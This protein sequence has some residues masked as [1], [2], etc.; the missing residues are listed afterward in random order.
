MGNNG[1]RI[2]I[3]S[4]GKLNSDFLKKYLENNRSDKI[5]C[6]DGALAIVDQLNIPIDYLVGDFD[7]ISSDVLQKYL[8]KIENGEM[9]TIV[10][11]FKP[12][13]D[14]T[15]TD[16]AIKLATSLKPSEII[17][18]GA[19]GTRVDHMMSNINS[20]FK[21]L[22]CNIKAFLIDEHNKI[23]LIKEETKLLKKELYGPFISLIAFTDKVLNVTLKGFKY[24]LLN[25]EL[26]KGESIGISN[27]MKEEE[28]VIELQKGII[29]VVEAKD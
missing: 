27:E 8:N 10:K 20:L 25:Y 13:K 26:T 15:D 23:Y 12:E 3:L 7:T 9:Q 29:M 17:I 4:G 24:P 1:D 19:T 16:I 11:K 28:A 2:L 14:Y 18:L 6:V 5:I 21:P 22:S